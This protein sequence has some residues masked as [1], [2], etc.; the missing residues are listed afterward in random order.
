M[1]NTQLFIPKK[2]KVGFQERDDTYTG[3]LAYV[4]YYD[5]KNKLRKEISWENWR[6]KEYD[7]THRWNSDEAVKGNP[8]LTPLDLDNVPTTGFV[9]NKGVGGQRQ[10]WGWNARNEYIRVYDPRNFEFEIS[11]AN[12]LFI[13]QECDSIKGKGLE[14][15]FVYSWEGKELVLLPVQTN[16]YKKCTE[17]TALQ[18]NKIYK[19]DMVEGCVYMDSKQREFVYLG[20]HLYYD[21]WENSLPEENRSSY[22]KDYKPKK[23]HIFKSTDEEAYN[24]Y[25]AKSGYAH[26][27]KRMTD[28]PVDEFAYLIDEFLN[29]SIYSSKVS[30]FDYVEI[31]DE[32]LIP[33]RYNNIHIESLCKGEKC[34]IY[35]TEDKNSFFV[36][37]SNS[38]WRTDDMFQSNQSAEHIKVNF[39]RKVKVYENNHKQT[40]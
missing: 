26:L 16:E 22:S 9:L 13:L 8:E 18:D 10:S 24:Q 27:R 12:L 28:K 21:G 36:S 11:V 2:I 30:H 5:N 14:G 37:T 29:H 17:Y 34:Y 33:D 3:K 20:Y 32:D 1:S 6:E 38:Y 25:E 35:K 31:R 7:T 23:R 4:I 40:I 15:E 19:K 39:K